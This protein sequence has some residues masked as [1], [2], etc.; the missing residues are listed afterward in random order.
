MFV[1]FCFQVI[2]QIASGFFRPSNPEEFCDIYN[3]LM[4][5]DC[6][7]CPADYDD[8]MAALERVNEAYKVKTHSKAIF[9]IKMS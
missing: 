1:F 7:F 8:Y 5:H 4:Y 2:D 6:F 9:E 3:N